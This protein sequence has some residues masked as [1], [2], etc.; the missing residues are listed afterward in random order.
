[1]FK[2]FGS[3]LTMRRD[4]RAEVLQA[5]REVYDGFWHRDIGAEGGTRL[6]WEGQAGLIGA[7]TEEL[8]RFHSVTGALGERFVLVRTAEIDRPEQARTA[9][10][11]ARDRRRMEEELSDAVAALFAGPV[12]EPRE[13]A[14]DEAER[15]IALADFV[16]R[17]RTPVPRD[18]RTREILLVPR[19]EA[20]TRLVAVLELLHAGLAMIG[21]DPAKAW[22]VVSKVALDSVPLARLR[23]LTV[24]AHADGTVTTSEVAARLRYPTKTVTTYL[25]DLEALALVDVERGG[26]GRANEWRLSDAGRELWTAAE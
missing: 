7:S 5:L 20:P 25:E 9:R 22:A 10:R 26:Q 13:L 16:S 23:A 24:L 17:A 3:V 19:P 6:V 8:E 15:L 18:D 12:A 14:D 1:V 2:D 11:H 21:V 4:A